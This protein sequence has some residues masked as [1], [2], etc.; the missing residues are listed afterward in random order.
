MDLI[1]HVGCRPLLR[2]ASIAQLVEQRTFNPLVV[3]SIP[4]GG[5]MKTI[6]FFLLCAFVILPFFLILLPIIAVTLVVI[7]YAADPDLSIEKEGGDEGSP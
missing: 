2:Y 5:T 1:R 7:Y 6:L 4:T 3:G